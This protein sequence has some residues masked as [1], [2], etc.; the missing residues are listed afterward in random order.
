MMAMQNARAVQA[1]Q[2]AHAAYIANLNARAAQ[3]AAVQSAAKR[4][5]AGDALSR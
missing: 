3:S 2:A 5:A 4:I 1:S